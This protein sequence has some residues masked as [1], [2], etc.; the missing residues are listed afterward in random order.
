MTANQGDDDTL[1]VNGMA[2]EARLLEA[3]PMR[4][5]RLEECQAHCCGGGVSISTQQAED[6]LAHAELIQPYLPPDRRDPLRWFDWVLEPEHDHPAGGT[7]TNTTVVADPTHPMGANCIFLRPDR[8]CGLQAAS[9]AAGEHPWRFKPFYCALHPITFDQC[10]V[11]LSEENPMYLEGGSCNRPDPAA[12]IPVYQ[13]FEAE[14]K[15]ALGEVGYAEMEAMA[16]M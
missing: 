7:L 3:K 4:H 12:L 13:L 10:V 15:L 16:D 8:K 2:V 6:I 11:K 5:C 9:I 14:M 1:I